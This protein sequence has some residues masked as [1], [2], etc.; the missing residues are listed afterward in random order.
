[1]DLGFFL[2]SVICL[3]GAALC[4]NGDNISCPCPNIPSFDLTEPP[5]ETC[6]QIAD[7]FR[8]TCIGGY[9][10]KAGT[11]NLIR[12]KLEDGSSKWS[13]P[14]LECITD[15]KIT[16]TQPP[17]STVTT[18]HTDIP[19]DSTIATSVTASPTA[20]KTQ[21]ISTTASVT[22]GRDRTE[23]TSAGLP[24]QTN[25]SQAGTVVTETK[26]THRT[27]STSTTTEPSS[28]R[29][30]SAKSPTA[31]FDHGSTT[32]AV[33]GCASLA[34]VIALIGISLYCYKRKSRNGIPPE[35]AQE[36]LYMYVPSDQA[37]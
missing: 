4:S 6:Y 18:R 31:A 5:P 2:F 24:A 21:S 26:G 7:V 37:S 15:P 25:H 29:N 33:I 10:R 12:C 14:S 9:S 1:M 11:S 16:K 28:N 35:P 20:E 13:T 34:F 3:L 8:Y 30:V 23:S 19:H 36:Q 32:T 27:T 22:T 17:K